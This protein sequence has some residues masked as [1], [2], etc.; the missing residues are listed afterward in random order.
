[1]NDAGRSASGPAVFDRRFEWPTLLAWALGVAV[2]ST[3]LLTAVTSTA[4]FDPFNPSWNG[5][6]DL[7]NHLESDPDVESELVRDTNSYETADPDE[8]VAIVIAPDEPY[9]GADA[10]R[11]QSFVDEGG[12]LVVFENVGAEGNA[13]LESVDADARV[14]GRLLRDEQH[15]YRGPKMPIA[16][17]VANH[18]ITADVDQLTLNH[19]TA[20]NPG[21]NETTELVTTSSIASLEGDGGDT[22][23]GTHIGTH[24]VA[25]A[26]SVGDGRVIVV[27]DPSIT[28]NAMRERPDNSAFIRGLYEDEERVLLDISHVAD[29]PV[30]A[31]T[32]ET[33]RATPLAQTLAGTTGIVL[34]A[35]LAGHRITPLW[36]RLT[37]WRSRRSRCHELE[38]TLTDAGRFSNAQSGDS[39]QE[40]RRRRSDRIQRV[41]GDDTDI[42]PRRDTP[43]WNRRD[44]RTDDD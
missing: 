41:R 29:P 37:R 39:R 44:E 8:T 12:T 30:L 38:E 13:L 5:T 19:G 3:L 33:V 27:G 9:T 6:A 17:G 20:V 4:A 2:V 40:N 22:G 11:V 18:S 7:R 26:E 1:M 16:T 32:I 21:S 23:N 35:A 43:E 28:I 36:R 24:P 14:D 31:M 34:I 15:Y 42:H 10:K 25:T